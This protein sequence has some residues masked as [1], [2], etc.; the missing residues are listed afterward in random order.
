MINYWWG[1]DCSLGAGVVQSVQ[2]FATGRTVRGSNPL[3][4]EIFRTRTEGPWGPPSFLYNGNRIFPG[5]KTT[6]S[7]R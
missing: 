1:V 6:G 7:W 2:G 5:D 3:W 4:S